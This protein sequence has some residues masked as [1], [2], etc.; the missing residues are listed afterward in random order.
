VPAGIQLCAIASDSRIV[1]VDD[2]ILRKRKFARQ[3]LNRRGGR[4]PPLPT[5]V[6]CEVFTTHK[7]I[8]MSPGWPQARVVAVCDG[9][10]VSLGD[11]IDDLKPWTERYPCQIGWRF[12]DMLMT[13]GFSVGIARYG[14]SDNTT[15]GEHERLTMEQ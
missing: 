12:E 11:K 13:P 10:I 9:R 2:L 6:Q 4:R 14:R 1:A 7:I 5:S 8:T 15:M 3:R